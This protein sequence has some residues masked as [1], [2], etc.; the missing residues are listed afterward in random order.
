[1]K[2]P[3]F[4]RSWAPV[5][6]RF[7]EVIPIFAYVRL[8]LLVFLHDF[9]KWFTCLKSPKAEMPV[10]ASKKRKVGTAQQIKQINDTQLFLW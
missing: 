4:L 3:A 10:N 6:K 8:F 9:Q 7:F 1:M 2:A 5:A